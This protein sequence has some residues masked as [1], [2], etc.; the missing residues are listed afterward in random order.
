M[1]NYY[2]L[3]E[4]ILNSTHD[5]ML[6]INENV[7]IIYNKSAEEILGLKKS[8]VIGKEIVAVLPSSLLPSTSIGNRHNKKQTIENGITIVTTRVPMIHN[9]KVVGALA[10]FKDIT[11]IVEMVKR[12]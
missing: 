9:G 7:E 12:K 8:T 4:L 10:V 5:G 6:A 1:E 11:E 2:A 3:Q